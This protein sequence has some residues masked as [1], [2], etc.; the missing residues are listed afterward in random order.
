MQVDIDI[1]TMLFCN[2]EDHVEMRVDVA[3]EA[4]GIKAAD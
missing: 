4:C 3:I 2:A 1:D